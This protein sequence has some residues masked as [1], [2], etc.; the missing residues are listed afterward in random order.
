MA[1]SSVI[2]ASQQKR[3]ACWLGFEPFVEPTGFDRTAQP[4]DIYEVFRAYYST[5]QT[6]RYIFSVSDSAT[7]L[8]LYH[9]SSYRYGYTDGGVDY[10]VDLN[11]STLLNG[12]YNGYYTTIN[13]DDTSSFP[14]TGTLQFNDGQIFTYTSKTATSFTGT[15][16]QV[17]QSDNANIWL[18][19]YTITWTGTKRW[20]ITNT[21]HLITRFNIGSTQGPLWL[22]CGK[23]ITII[24]SSGGGV[25][26][27]TSIKW[28]HVN[29]LSNLTG[30]GNHFQNSNL[31]GN[32]Y[33]PTNAVVNK[34]MNYLNSELGF[35]QCTGLTG[36]LT[37]PGNI[38]T[39]A[40]DSN[41][42]GLLPFGSCTGFT[43]LILEEGV[44]YIR[45]GSF[46]S[47]TSITGTLTIP[48]TMLAIDAH[49]FSYCNFTHIVSNSTG[50]TVYDE[51]LYDITVGGSIKANHSARGYSGTIT[52]KS[53]CTEVLAYC[54]ASNSLRTGALIIPNTITQIGSLA[55]NS[56]T[57]ITGLSFQATSVCTLINSQAFRYDSKLTGTLTL[58]D[59]MITLGDSAFGFCR[60]T[61]LVL[62]NSLVT[63]GAACFYNNPLTGNIVFP[64]TLET[65]ADG[66]SFSGASFTGSIHIPTAMT[67]LA[68]IG[69]TFYITE[70]TGG[71]T[72]YPI[73]DNVVYDCKTS[74]VIKAF[75]NATSYVGTLTLR[76][77]TT[78]IHSGCFVRN[79]RTGTLDIPSTVTTIENY[80]FNNTSASTLYTEGFS[81]ITSSST[82]YPVS[83]NV[84]YDCKTSGLVKAIYCAINST[85]T[86]TFRADTTSI[87]AYCCSSCDG[88]TGSLTIP[89]TVTA[90]GSQAF[91]HCKGFTGS[92]IVNSTNIAF[93]NSTFGYAGYLYSADAFTALEICS[94][95]SNTMLYFDFC[96][97]FSATSLNTSILNLTD[98]TKTF[99]IGGTNKARLLASYPNAV[100][101]A[102]ARGIT[103]V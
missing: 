9:G 58:P 50:F 81:A 29:K 103:I 95:F 94:G 82:N 93:N 5:N 10:V 17:T 49:S 53:D 92:L 72:T 42:W 28:I 44:Q 7:T 37:I 85:G 80:V 1:F 14:S 88:R 91:F 71:S 6:A 62:G 97:L 89:N 24:D 60:W 59:S 22:Y 2:G 51:I 23:D 40:Q 26:T 68:Y 27:K 56:C 65:I 96:S 11:T 70:F 99:R 61:G 83:D 15:K 57:N 25:N 16:Q 77:D 30:C 101:D 79:K 12:N 78:H 19:T 18:K 32:L 35:Q 100:T 20:V 36:T 34:I 8:A 47:C 48:S 13:V 76:A 38:K 98:G 75:L 73:S 66:N 67:T 90:I 33:L 64:D 55:Y 46:I 102:V 84:L 43:G 54:C 45:V 3:K 39:V 86:L 69:S 74:G 4:V 41:P 52:M 63:I 21:T 87:E 31:S